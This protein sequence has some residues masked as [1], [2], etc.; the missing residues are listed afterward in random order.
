MRKTF[1]VCTVLL[2]VGAL[3]AACGDRRDEAA[4]QQRD[5]YVS[6]VEAR[7]ATFDANMQDFEKR[8]DAIAPERREEFDRTVEGLKGKRDATAKSLD[9]ARN[10]EGAEWENARVQ[11]DAALQDLESSL[12]QAYAA[13]S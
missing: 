12:S 11:T 9:R 4:K 5:A 7:L 3:F 13:F 6:Q 10:A 1:F 2:L 8:R